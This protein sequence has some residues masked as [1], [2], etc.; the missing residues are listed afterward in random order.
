[1]PDTAI[2][3]KLRDTGQTV[4]DPAED[5][6][7]RT[8]IDNDDHEI[9]KVHDLLVDSQKHKV[10]MLRVE[11]GGILGLGATTSFVPIEAISRITEDAVYINQPGQ[12]LAA[13]PVYDPDLEDQTDYYTDLYG[14]YGYLPFGAPGYTNPGFPRDR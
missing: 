13:A 1:M 7:G 2:L 8:V 3:I 6:R 4:T 12:H 9:G 5:V 14:Y 11:H 10:R